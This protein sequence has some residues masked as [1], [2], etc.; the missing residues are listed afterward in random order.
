MIFGVPRSTLQFRTV[1]LRIF[2]KE[3]RPPKVQKSVWFEWEIEDV[4]LLRSPNICRL[5]W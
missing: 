2:G 1:V 5:V 4:S 3:K